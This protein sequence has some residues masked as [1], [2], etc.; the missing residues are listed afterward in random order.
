MF[1]RLIVIENSLID[2]SI[3]KKYPVLSETVF[4]AND[5]ERKSRM[6]KIRVPD[7]DIDELVNSLTHNLITPYYCHLYVEDPIDDSLIVIFSG[8]KFFAKKSNYQNAKAYGLSHGVTENEMQISP[9]EVT[10]EEW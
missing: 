3:L 6:L 5:P 7:Q 10:K 2:K 4:A 9:V 1:Y 8:Q